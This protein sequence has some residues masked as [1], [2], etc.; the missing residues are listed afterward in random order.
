MGGPPYEEIVRQCCPAET[1]NSVESPMME[2]SHLDLSSSN[3]ATPVVTA[4]TVVPPVAAT[5]TTTTPVA[6]HRDL[7]VFDKEFTEDF[8][9]PTSVL[10][11][12]DN[13][14]KGR[15]RRRA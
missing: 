3:G 4:S 14:S 12:S 8:N 5:V 13:V 9:R 7:K 2:V 10:Q 1:C 11:L 6:D 15:H